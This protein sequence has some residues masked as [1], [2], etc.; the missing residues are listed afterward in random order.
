MTTHAHS[1][2]ATVRMTGRVA[3]YASNERSAGQLFQAVARHGF[4]P[5]LFTDREHLVA[6]LADGDFSAC[7]LDEPSSPDFVAHVENAI[8]QSGASTQLV[9]LPPLGQRSAVIPEGSKAEVV[10]TPHTV[11]RI[12]RTLFAA[13]GRA[14]LVEEN[15]KLRTERDDQ[16]WPE[17]I[18]QSPAMA[19]LR[20]L[21][22]PTA[23]DD[24]P[25]VV[26]GEAGCGT[27]TVARAIHGGRTARRT[28]LVPLHCRVLSA[29]AAEAALF[30]GA[31]A[32]DGPESAGRLESASGGSLL[33]DDVAELP[34]SIQAKLAAHMAATPPDQ[35]PKLRLIATIHGNPSE[36]IR[37][38]RLD[39]R[40][41]RS[42]AR[43]VIRVPSLRERRADV[44]LLAE[45]FLAEY[46]AR[47]GRPQLQL[48]L[49]GM[50]R[51][52]AYNW[53]GNVRELEN[54]VSRCCALAD[55]KFLTAEMVAPWLAGEAESH[56]VSISLSLREM[57][58]KLIETTFTRFNGNRELT[59][60]AL[61]I[62][63]RT[64]SGKLRE[65]GYPPR[66]GPGSNRV[67][68]AA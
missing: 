6:G 33:L 60:R 68:R 30:G 45:H 13:I 18:G 52:E 1:P 36:L 29:L 3:V 34:L 67:S 22:R 39:E 31:D 35:Q 65:Y 23:E 51:L 8:N 11:D 57:E 56:P 38:G 64:L 44:A 54:V 26:L 16:L 21:L 53:P 12:G 2:S 48:T 15:L 7:L 17:L 9:V 62:G 14:R 32:Q 47:E 66:G 4:K 42:L 41:Y 19:Q 27:T 55:A 59:A 46:A 20:E 58:R 37:E 61:K 5:T 24:A 28:P 10:E 40:L 63:L 50:K 25:V 49:D 43:H